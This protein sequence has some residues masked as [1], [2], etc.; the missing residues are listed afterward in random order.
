MAD[1]FFEQPILNSPYKCPAQ[2]WELGAD[3]Q[4]TNQLV[5]KRR[6]AEFFTPIPKPKKQRQAKG[7]QKELILSSLE[8][9]ST[10]VQQ[11]DPNPVIAFKLRERLSI[12]A[13]TRKL[14]QGHGPNLETLETEG[15]MLQRVMP[16]LMGMKNVL[17]IND[18]AH[19]CY[20]EKPQNDDLDDL[21]GEEKDEAK[22]NNEAARLWISGIEMVKRLLGVN[23]V[24]DL[25]ATPFFLRGSG[26]A[27]GTLFPWTMSDFSLMDAIECGIVKLPRVP[28]ADNIPGGEMPKFR[29]LWEHIRTKM[30]KKGRGKATTLDPLSLPAELQTAL[31]ALYGHY[32]QTYDLWQQAG[33]SVP[34]V[35]IVVCNNTSTSKLVHDF[36]SGFQRIG[37]DGETETYYPG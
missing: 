27:E 34:P 18:E 17:V 25:S 10:D 11:Y 1:R 6:R 9:L 8:G 20:R 19:H 13:G 31:D 36:I 3:G 4:P 5:L 22:K 32:Q 23:R 26:Y 37:D 14:L 28:V 35:F 33:I 29:N 7:V 16:E 15:Q 30:P 24:Y 2:H 12:A 21:K